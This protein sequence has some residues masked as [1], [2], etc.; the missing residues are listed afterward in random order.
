MWKGISVYGKNVCGCIYNVW[1]KYDFGRMLNVLFIY[2]IN[3]I[4]LRM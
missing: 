2:F 3:V 4:L 1:F